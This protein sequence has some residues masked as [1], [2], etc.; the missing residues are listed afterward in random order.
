MEFHCL[1]KLCE[2]NEFPGVVGFVGFFELHTSKVHRVPY[3]MKTRS[4]V[5]EL[6]TSPKKD[7]STAG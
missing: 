5:A 6:T 1:I 2:N 7:R 4:N 3:T